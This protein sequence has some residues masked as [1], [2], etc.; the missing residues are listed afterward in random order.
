M[1][2]VSD[3]VIYPLKSGCGVKVTQAVAT[4]QGLAQDALQDR[5]VV[6]FSGQGQGYHIGEKKKKKMQY[7]LSV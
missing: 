4:E 5:L 2:E 6:L 1:G 7:M 3:L